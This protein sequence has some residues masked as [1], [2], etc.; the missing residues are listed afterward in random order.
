MRQDEEQRK[1][2]FARCAEEWDRELPPEKAARLGALCAEFSVPAGGRV[3]D[4][5]CGTGI[6]V[7]FLRKAAGE[8]GMIFE[9]DPNEAMIARARRK[10]GGRMI[11]LLAQAERIPLPEDYADSLV[12]Y[13][14]FPHFEDRQ[15]A[16]R[17]FFRVLKPGAFAHVAHLASSEEIDM[18]H[19][20]CMVVMHDRMPTDAEMAEMF[21][22]CGFVDVTLQNETGRYLLKARKPLPGEN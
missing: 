18:H 10:D 12:A 4:I 2:F 9:L 3:L 17:E 19:A 8:A 14:C 22:A 16:V 5:G 7:P 6:L 15:Q 11:P 13:A 20:S 21:R 1:A